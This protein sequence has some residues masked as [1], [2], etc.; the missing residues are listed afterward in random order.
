[1]IDTKEMRPCP[2]CMRNLGLPEVV[3]N[4]PEPVIESGLFPPDYAD[5]YRN[6]HQQLEDGVGRLEAI[7]PLTAD[8]IPFHVRYT[9][10]Y[11]ENGRPLKAYGS[12]VQVVDEDK[13]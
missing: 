5:M 10:E 1:M 4:Y 6:W 3:K 2:R 7:I 11:D 9:T 13:N 12:A 8:R